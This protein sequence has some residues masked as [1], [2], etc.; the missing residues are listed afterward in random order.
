MKKTYMVNAKIAGLILIGL[1]AF[2]SCTKNFKEFNTN[3]PYEGLDKDLLGDNYS[4]GAFFPQ[5]LKA[6]IPPDANQYQRQQ[7]LVGDI[8]SGQMTVIGTWNSGRNN[9]TY[10]IPTLDW[11]DHPFE[12]VFTNAFAAFNQIKKKTNSDFESHSLSWAQ[13]LKIASMH[14]FTDTWGPL[15][16][17]GLGVGSLAVKYDSQQEVY[18]S[19]FI[20]ITKA[21]DVLT[22]FVTR[23]PGVTPMAEFDMVYG[24]DYVKWI[25]FANSLKLRL[26]MRI[27]DVNP[28]LAQAMAEEAVSHQIGVI[29]SNDDN[30]Q[31]QTSQAS[32]MTNPLFTISITQE[33][34]CMGATAQSIMV[35][36]E[37]PRLGAY[38][39]QVSIN[40]KSGYY[41]T[42]TGEIIT[43]NTE[44]KKFSRIKVL[45]STPLMWMNASEV[46]FL[47]AEGAVRNWAMG[48]TAEAA[49]NTG[50]RLSME[51]NNVDPTSTASYIANTDKKPIDFVNPIFPTQNITAASDITIKWDDAAT[52]EK[53]LERLITQKWIAVFPNGAEAWAEYRRT[54]YPKQFPVKNNHSNGN[55]DS[56]I[57][58][59]RMDFPPNEKLLNA[60][61]YEQ[62]VTLLGGPDHGGTPLWWDTKHKK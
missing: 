11:S 24:G 55:I 61:N 37:D 9:Q 53:K 6:V 58:I 17:S 46:A 50:I 54:G 45:P 59:R 52:D 56:N 39:T 27:S 60:K 40:D 25:K 23:N 4:V 2:S 49:Y 20:E 33:E 32:T 57:G 12:K 10:F 62:A 42:R 26:A 22:G 1:I 44:Y 3:N 15:P 34:C 51:Q 28:T 38:F 48:T 41:G 36:Y 19:F 35:G 18:E 47:M 30:A 21:I 13:I 5:L 14:R 8:F 29:T 16:Y 31:I 7:N 43:T